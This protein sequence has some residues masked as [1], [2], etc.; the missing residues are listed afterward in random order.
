MEEEED[1]EA[2]SDVEDGSTAGGGAASDDCCSRA[3]L[4]AALFLGFG[5]A[6]NTNWRS[7]GEGHGAAAGILEGSAVKD[8]VA[9]L[10]AVIGAGGRAGAP[11]RS[12]AVDGSSVQGLLLSVLFATATIYKCNARSPWQQNVPYK[13]HAQVVQRMVLQ[14]QLQLTLEADVL[15]LF[16][17]TP[18]A[19]E[20]RE[21]L[22]KVGA[23]PSVVARCM[24]YRWDEAMS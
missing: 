21:R 2:S 9:K 13:S 5:L 20:M 24:Q 12:S 18:A 4:C 3:S 22:I 23:L 17:G 7:D 15:A 1:D 8:E 11:I 10:E 16:E 19:V 14:S 6:T